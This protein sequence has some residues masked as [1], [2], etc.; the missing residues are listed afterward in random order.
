MTTATEEHVDVEIARLP[1]SIQ[2]LIQLVRE[3]RGKMTP[4]LA[5]QCVIDA[6]VNFED[7]MPWADFG[8]PLRDGYG[9]K[10]IYHGGDFEIMCMSW[11]PGDF[12]SIHDHGTAQWGAVKS[13]G[14]AEHGVFEMR[15]DR[16]VTKRRAPVYPGQVNAV[17][18][19]LIHQMGNRGQA[20]FCSLHMYGS[21]DHNGEITGDSRIFELQHEVIECTTGG[22]FFALPESDISH[23]LDGVPA[24]YV[25]TQRHHAEKLLRIHRFLPFLEDE[26]EAANFRDMARDLWQSLLSD[27]DSEWQAEE[28]RDLLDDNGQIKNMDDWNN[29]FYELKVVAETKA[30]LSSNYA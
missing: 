17:T 18:H 8:H 13:F 20:P 25:T 24:D 29:F 7:V 3:H 1:Q 4:E 11:V 15:D 12:S 2:R 5:R 10:M 23:R 16:L 21:Y 28:Q 14:L 19:E 27:D 22:V 9:R 26:K 6:E 30:K